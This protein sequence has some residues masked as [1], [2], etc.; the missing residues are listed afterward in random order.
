MIGLGECYF[1]KENF[2]IAAQYLQ[3][4]LDQKDKKTP[5]SHVSRLLGESFLCLKLF[6]L[7]EN[8]L[9]RSV[10]LEPENAENWSILAVLFYS[11]NQ[12][13][14]AIDALNKAI[15][16]GGSPK[17]DLL[18]QRA[19]CYL[20]FQNFEKA[21]DD[22]NQALLIDPSSSKARL[23]R[24]QCLFNSEKFQDAL[25]DFNIFIKE[26]ETKILK[27][28]KESSE[29]LIDHFL[30][31][32]SLKLQ[33]SLC[34]IYIYAQTLEKIPD[35]PKH[36]KTLGQ[37][38]TTNILREIFEA[39]NSCPN[40]NLNNAYNDI[41]EARSLN[42]NNPLLLSTIFIFK[43]FLENYFRITPKI[44]QKTNQKTNPPKI[45]PQNKFKK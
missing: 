20:Y 11:T 32:A 2:Q 26:N 24:A 33:R 37:T 29:I 12:F 34:N 23:T 22:S 4:A 35:V 25:L 5:E 13:A 27:I 28:D 18:A 30:Q 45:T 44:Y 10:E 43:A 3:M 7:A 17:Q 21:N 19:S 36:P 9:K 40:Q 42:L 15:E 8:P 38:E 31:L 6:E 39:L 16:L 41:I 1:K 14:Q